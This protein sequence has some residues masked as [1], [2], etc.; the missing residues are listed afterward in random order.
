[1]L[2][3][4]SSDFD[5][6]DHGPAQCR[7]RFIQPPRNGESLPHDSD[8][9]VNGEAHPDWSLH[10]VF[11][12]NKTNRVTK[13]LPDPCEE[14]LD[15]PPA[16]MQRCDFDFRPRRAVGPPPGF[17]VLILMGKA[18]M[19]ART[20]ARQRDGLIPAENVI[21]IV[22]MRIVARGS[23]GTSLTL[24]RRRRPRGDRRAD[25][26]RWSHDTRWRGLKFGSHEVRTFLP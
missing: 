5:S 14:Q 16:S 17:G 3:T 13:V 1:M 12:P 21:R 15:M 26:N 22:G 7:F 2:L 24:Q 18:E 4:N 8:L 11:G 20:F 25:G 19:L 9:E 23:V 10:R 6:F